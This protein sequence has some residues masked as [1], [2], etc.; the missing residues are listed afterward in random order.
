MHVLDC[1]GHGWMDAARLLIARFNELQ[2]GERLEVRVSDFPAELRQWLL[3]AGIRHRAARNGDWRIATRREMCPAQGSVNGFHHTVAADD[4]SVW[5]CKRSPLVARIDAATGSVAASAPVARR[6]AHMAYDEQTR[7]LFVA[8]SEANEVIALRAGD[9][10][11]QQ[12][13]AVPGG[14]Q[15]PTVSPNGIVGVTGGNSVTLA[16]PIQGAYVPQT[17]EV[18]SCPHD[19]AVGRDGEH[20]FVPCM[21]GDLVKLRL[22]DGRIVGR[23]NVGDGPSHIAR[24]PASSR[25]YVATSWDGC[26]SC[27]SEEGELIARADSG[28]WAH[29]IAITPNGKEVWVANFLDDTMAVFDA[30]TLGRLAVLET[31]AYPHGLDIS[32]DGRAVV[33]TGYSSR[34]ARIFDAASRELLA[35]VEVGRGGSHAAFGHGK[36]LIACSVDDWI[37]PVEMTAF[38]VEPVVLDLNSRERA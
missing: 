18:G 23:A 19:P 1:S 38:A 22:S 33:V 29:A 16:R 12:R 26:V 5:A 3:E 9:L 8:D 36:A 28:G 21:G 20:L 25:L 30:Q 2:E 13:W 34:H 6:A 32:P 24:H 14:P 35:R 17:I 15:L 11:V 37:A 10:S 27:V 31:D 7:L 4:G